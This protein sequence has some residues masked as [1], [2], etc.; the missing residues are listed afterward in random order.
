MAYFYVINFQMIKFTGNIFLIYAT[1]PHTNINI[2]LSTLKKEYFKG[3]DEML[4][5]KLFQ[6]IL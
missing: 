6:E 5:A 4:N 3:S 1:M 2:I